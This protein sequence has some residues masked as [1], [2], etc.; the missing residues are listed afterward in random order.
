[1]DPPSF[2][3]FLVP[4]NSRQSVL[5]RSEGRNTHLALGALLASHLVSQSLDGFLFRLILSL[6][7]FLFFFF[8]RSFPFFVRLFIP[9]STRTR[10]CCYGIFVCLSTVLQKIFSGGLSSRQHHHHH[11]HRHHHHRC[12]LL[13]LLLHLLLL[14]F[15]GLLLSSSHTVT[16]LCVFFLILVRRP[17][18]PPYDYLN[19]TMAT[20]YAYS[21][22]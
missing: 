16:L 1:M 17:L 7:F 6:F 22:S 14:L 20:F 19:M 21:L 15:L 2:F 13:L 5:K 8:F 11:Y 3:F 10:S 12:P 9:F 4:L 18:L